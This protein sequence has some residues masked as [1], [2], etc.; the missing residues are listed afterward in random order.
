MLLPEEN[1]LAIMK[2]RFESL[3][4]SNRWYPVLRRYIDY[5]AARVDGLGGDADGIPPSPDGAPILV[6]P[7][8]REVVIHRGK[9]CEVVYDCFGDF[10]GFALESCCD[11]KIHFKTRRHA[12]G[13]LVLRVCKDRLPIA[14]HVEKRDPHKIVS[15]TVEC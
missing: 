3:P 11:E 2:W 12:I 9:V 15:I 8:L 1:T 13:E 5:I 14:V 10:E 4:A 6:K 7:G